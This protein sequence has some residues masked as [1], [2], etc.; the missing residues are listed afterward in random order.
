MHLADLEASLITLCVI[1]TFFEPILL[2][3]FLQLKQ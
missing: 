1:I 2:V 3:C